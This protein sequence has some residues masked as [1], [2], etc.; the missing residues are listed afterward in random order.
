MSFKD[1]SKFEKKMNFEQGF[2]FSN[3]RHL[4][5]TKKTIEMMKKKK[6]QKRYI[7]LFNNNYDPN[8]PTLYV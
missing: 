5:L 6:N 4:F 7:E 8:P 3:E 2:K 1:I